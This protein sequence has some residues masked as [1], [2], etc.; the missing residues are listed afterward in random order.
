M[1]RP[2][3]LAVMAWL[4]PGSHAIEFLIRID[5]RTAVHPRCSTSSA[6]ASSGAWLLVGLV[7]LSKKA[8][9]KPALDAALTTLQFILYAADKCDVANRRFH[10][11]MQ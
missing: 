6:H 10:K 5:E 1:C 4:G 7:C 3:L 8:A 11:A 2:L 9:P